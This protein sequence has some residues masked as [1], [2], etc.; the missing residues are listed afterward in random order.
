MQNIFENTITNVAKVLNDAGSP[1]I[2]VGGWAV[3]LLGVTRQT[4]DFDMMIFQDLFEIAKESLE[5]SGY[6]MQVKTKLYARFENKNAVIEL[7][8]TLFADERTY[9]ILSSG[10]EENIC[11]GTFILPKKEHIIAMKL[12]AVKY[13]EGHRGSKDFQDITDIIK[14]NDIDIY[15]KDFKQLC[16]KYGEESI[17]KRIKNECET[18]K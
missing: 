16:L 7:I 6:H 3:N 15:T 14:A 5:K 1:P 4:L 9:N 12:H 2:L 13:G 11:G 8:D 10:T 18:T 17:Y